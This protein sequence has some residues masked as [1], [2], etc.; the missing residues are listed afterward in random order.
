MEMMD[1]NESLM[2]LQ[3]GPDEDLKNKVHSS[4]ESIIEELEQEKQSILSKWDESQDESLLPSM[5]EYYLKMKYI[6]RIK[7]Q[8]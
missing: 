7:E 4:L 8:L 5:T 2:E 3:F 1:I 6:N